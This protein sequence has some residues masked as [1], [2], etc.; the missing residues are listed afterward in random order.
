MSS[1]SQFV[2]LKSFSNKMFFSKNKTEELI[3][4]YKELKYG[5]SLK[6]DK[7]EKYFDV[8]YIDNNYDS[9]WV[10]TETKEKLMEVFC[11]NFNSGFTCLKD[12]FNLNPYNENNQI[13]IDKSLAKE[14]ILCLEYFI[15]YNL[16]YD[17]TIERIINSEFLDLFGKNIPSY[18]NFIN[19]TSD[20][21][22]SE[23]E[24]YALMDY[25]RLLTLLKTF[26]LIYDS[27]EF[28]E[29][30]IILIYLAF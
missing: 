22:D 25:N 2:F 3:K 19:N 27:F 14:M 16:N 30:N 12:H 7:I 4:K 17:K 21:S 15:N 28:S 10:N 26:L 23:S 1:G 9:F 6:N 13:L 24:K 8:G 18:L 11:V 29:E 5:N 20:F